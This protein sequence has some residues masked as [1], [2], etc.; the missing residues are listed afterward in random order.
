[1]VNKVKRMI[2]F[3]TGTV[4][5]NSE[6]LKPPRVE[7]LSKILIT[8]SLAMFV[9]VTQV[10]ALSPTPP[11]P[12]ALTVSVNQAQTTLTLN[13]VAANDAEY[14]IVDGYLGGAWRN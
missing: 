4:K 3:I 13:W 2:F 9:S 1:M 14:Y 12:P 6:S 8:I 7:L 5:F 10:L 11:E